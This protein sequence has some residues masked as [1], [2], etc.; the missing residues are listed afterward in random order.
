[1]D[2]GQAMSNRDAPSI[3]Q[4]EGSAMAEAGLADG[5]V[6]L[7]SPP[8]RA[9]QWLW[10]VPRF[11]LRTILILTTAVCVALGFSVVRAERQRMACEELTRNRWEWWFAGL[12]EEEYR[13]QQL[14]TNE[15]WWLRR[16]SPEWRKSHGVH[17][18]RSV[19]RVS[20]DISHNPEVFKALAQLSALSRLVV[21]FSRNPDDHDLW[22][23][24][25]RIRTLREL[26]LSESNIDDAGMVHVGRLRG[27]TDLSLDRTIVSDEGAR[28]LAKLTS[29]E[30][31]DLDDTDITDASIATLAALPKLA[32]LRLSN[33]RVSPDG[34]SALT[35]LPQDLQIFDDSPL[36]YDFELH[37]YLTDERYHSPDDPPSATQDLS[38]D[39][40]FNFVNVDAQSPLTSQR[41]ATLATVRYVHKLKV[42]GRNFGDTELAHLKDWRILFQAYFDRTSIS[43]EG[44]KRLGSVSTLRELIVVGSP[45]TAQDVTELEKTDLNIL[46]LCD[47]DI[48]SETLRAILSLPTLGD[49]ELTNCRLPADASEQFARRDLGFYRLALNGTGMQPEAFL[50]QLPR[51]TFVELV[52]DG[53]EVSES[54]VQRLKGE[55]PH[56]HTVLMGDPTT[57]RSFEPDEV[58][59]RLSLRSKFVDEPHIITALAGSPDFRTVDFCGA[60]AGTKT[61]DELAGNRF[62]ESLALGQTHVSD[63]DLRHAA[64]WTR[65]RHLDLAGCAITDTGI[66]QLAPCWRL[67]SLWLDKT[68][69]GDESMKTIAKLKRLQYL[70]LRETKI[71]DAGLLELQGLEHLTLLRLGET[72]VTP[73]AVAELKERW[74]QCRID[75]CG[76]EVYDA[77]RFRDN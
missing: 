13:D 55:S 50:A 77:P 30:S 58:F 66:A 37:E 29:L 42:S 76:L 41:L 22:P 4:G 33:T 23:I 36:E 72:Q 65:L 32:T 26:T 12:R 53:V 21:R 7:A 35:Q 5:L 51:R 24:V 18:W 61:M 16:F 14:L 69:V 63:A 2:G 17:Y 47:C 43:H 25:G 54:V 19:D 1:M 44:F 71:T 46:A 11:S 45:V 59:R 68:G 70:S 52:W 39:E 73:Q 31:L 15:P 6:I 49:L 9:S 34:L 20:D 57:G 8:R 56:H 67:E 48:D 40:V 62:L 74:P 3:D 38:K 27:L 60:G 28:H 75:T 64:N 10:L